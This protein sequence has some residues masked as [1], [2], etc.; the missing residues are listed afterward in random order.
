MDAKVTKVPKAPS[1]SK[2]TAPPPSCSSE[3]QASLSRPE[4]PKAK[5]I[6]IPGTMNKKRRFSDCLDD[7]DLQLQKRKVNRPLFIVGSF[8][9]DKPPV[10]WPPMFETICL[11]PSLN[12]EEQEGDAFSDRYTSDLIFYM[13]DSDDASS[14]GDELIEFY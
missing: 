5:P 7:D 11:D 14:C 6:N 8:E 2:Q 13:D 12:W 9:E 3:S 4:T 1:D 10:P